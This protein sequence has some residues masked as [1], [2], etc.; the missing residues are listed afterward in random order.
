MAA[1]GAGEDSWFLG[2]FELVISQCSALSPV[3]PLTM[4]KQKCLTILTSMYIFFT[5]L[6]LL[7]FRQAEY[8]EKRC[9]SMSKLQHNRDTAATLKL[10]ILLRSPNCLATVGR[11]HPAHF[12]WLNISNKIKFLNKAYLTIKLAGLP[13]EKWRR[14]TF[15]FF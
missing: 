6:G 4:T 14:Q 2:G 3:S 11:S 9:K 10:K 13:F 15:K 8:Y 1:Q 5:I 12:T 7:R